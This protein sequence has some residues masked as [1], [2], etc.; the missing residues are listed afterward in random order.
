MAEEE[1]TVQL[2]QR[3][4]FQFELHFDAAATP[5]L[6][7]EPPPLGGGA[8]PSPVQLLLGAVGNCLAASLLFA[9][10]KF[11]LPLQPAKAAATASIGRE[12]GRLRVVG[13]Q[14]RLTLDQPVVE[15]PQY[16]ERALAQFEGFCT[17]SQSVA[18]GI[19]IQTQVFDADARRLK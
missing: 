12:E 6:L 5:V 19:P 2:V 11:K 13:I 4:D 3:Q 8:G 7:D 9:L 10:R 17:V 16:L 1:V 15:M 14:V 18:K